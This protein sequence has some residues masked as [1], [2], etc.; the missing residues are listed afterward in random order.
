MSDVNY[1][2]IRSCRVGKSEDL[3]S[4]LN[5]GHQALTGVFP[6]SSSEPVTVGPLELVWSPSSGLLQLKHS[7]EASEMYGDNYGYRSGLN[8]SMVDHLTNKV[9]YLERLTSISAGDVV[10]DIGSNDCTTLKAYAVPDV[11]RIGI[12][13]TGKKFASFYPDDVKLVSDFFSADAY[14]SVC[15]K[16]AKIVTSIAM[17]Y[18]L[19]DPVAFARQ[20]AD[21]LAPDG[22]WHFEQSYMPSMLRL[23]SYDTICHEHI[24]YYSLGPIQ[25]ILD[26]ADLKIVDVV[27]NNVN[28]GSFAV[29]ATKKS[30]SRFAANHAVIDWLLGQE[31]R[32]GLSTP[33]PYRDFE[34]RVFRHR[35]DLSNLIDALVADGKKILGY[36]ASTKGNVVLQFCNLTAAQIPAIAEVNEEKFGRF[37]PGSH[38]PIIS[39]EEARAMEPDY[40]LVLPWH[41]KDSILRRERDYLASGGKFIFPFPEIEII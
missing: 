22:V 20:V 1:T 15:D 28:G 6:K 11:R 29:T 39:E 35:E 26:A 9:R 40:F 19:E 38:I 36:G 33:R 14:R 34:E 27:M 2:A 31:D 30:N 10:L 8:Q 17:F 25:K 16:G 32:M 24:E 23:N 7:Y 12:D 13:P 21:V 18:D 3:I 41:F 4:V 5:L 37:T